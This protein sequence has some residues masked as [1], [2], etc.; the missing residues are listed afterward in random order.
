[1]KRYTCTKRYYKGSSVISYKLEDEKGNTFKID[2]EPLKEGI[3]LGNI[4]VTNLRLTDDNRLYLSDETVENSVKSTYTEDTKLRYE[5]LNILLINYNE[6]CSKIK[7]D[8]CGGTVDDNIVSAYITLASKL[9]EKATVSIVFDKSNNK[10]FVKSSINKKDDKVGT[11]NE[12]MAF[13]QYKLY[14]FMQIEQYFF[15]DTLA[16]E[17]MH[18]FDHLEN[19][20]TDRKTHKI[21]QVGSNVIYMGPRD[22]KAEFIEIPSY[23]TSVCDFAFEKCTNLMCI[24]CERFLNKSVEKV[25]PYSVIKDKDNKAV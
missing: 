8:D 2:S 13:V 19:I 7:I 11:K 24:N 4:K 3:K 10:F 17:R 14:E 22:N 20:E 1:M 5:L 18:K 25:C 9:N 21:L 12:T 16:I 23:V 15:I 6:S